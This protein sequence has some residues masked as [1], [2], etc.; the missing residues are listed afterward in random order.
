MSD[1]RVVD[2][3]ASYSR[4]NEINC[5]FFIGDVGVAR[6][7]HFLSHYCM[8]F[9]KIVYVPVLFELYTFRFG[10]EVLVVLFCGSVNVSD[11][12]L[13]KIVRAGLVLWDYE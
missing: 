3:V 9:D 12:L 10:F 5:S 13:D 1:Y 6:G 2:G 11:D 7:Y 4:Y 8:G